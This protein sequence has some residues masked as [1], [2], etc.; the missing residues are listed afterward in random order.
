[1]KIRKKLVVAIFQ[2]VLSFFNL[3]NHTCRTSSHQ[4]L[5]LLWR[6]TSHLPNLITPD[7][8]TFVV[9]NITAAEHHTRVDYFCG[10][11][12]D[13]CQ[14]SHPIRLLL[15]CRISLLLNITPGTTLHWSH[16]ILLL[17]W[18]RTS[19]LPNITPAEHHSRHNSS[20]IFTDSLISITDTGTHFNQRET[21]AD[22]VSSSISITDTGTCVAN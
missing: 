21:K 16:P 2:L 12:H 1:M 22:W 10:A 8:I 11:E 19:L 6:R 17:L 15:L 7:S 4:I 14:T 3:K 9:P 18:C 20:L 5:L 13:T